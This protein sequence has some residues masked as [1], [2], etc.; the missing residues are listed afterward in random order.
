MNWK[1]SCAYLLVVAALPCSNVYSHEE[2]DPVLT[3]L[4]V[5]KFETGDNTTNANADLWIGKDINKLWL[6]TNVTYQQGKTEDAELQALFS[7]A[8][9]PYWDVQIG[10]RQD[11]KPTPARTWGVLGVNGLA[12]Y[13]FDVD[14]AIFLGEGGR[15][16]ARLSAEY[17]VL[18]TQ[19]LILSPEVEFNFYG[20]SD[21]I[22]GTGSGL[23]NASVGLQL[24]YEIRREFAPYIGVAR[25]TKFGKSADMATLTGETKSDTQWI[26]GL[27]TWF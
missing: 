19:K 7:H 21:A 24:R 6:K 9:A 10:V 11:I 14:A 2:D 1:K 18:F 15:T 25:D 26:I 22:T 23:S 20:Q 17:D 5:N 13:F 4:M 8:I 3:K 16:A 27:R 12:P